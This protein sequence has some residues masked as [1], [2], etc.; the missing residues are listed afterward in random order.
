ME[1]PR[2]INGQTVSKQ[3]VRLK[4]RVM[5][6][7]IVMTIFVVT[8]VSGNF[9]VSVPLFNDFESYELS[10]ALLHQPNLIYVS[11]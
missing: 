7:K 6:F 1:A 3:N 10:S 8:W 11:S 4:Q 5:A 2:E 9:S